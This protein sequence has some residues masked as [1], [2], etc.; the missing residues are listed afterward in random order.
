LQCL[1]LG[2]ITE[3]FY[4]KKLVEYR[5]EQTNIQIKQKQLQ[6]VDE[7]YY[8]TGFYLLKLA[9]KDPAIFKSS[10][11]EV[12]RQLINLVGQNPTINDETL[13]A[14]YRNPFSM[15]AKGASS[16][17]WLLLFSFEHFHQ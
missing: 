15:F 6:G 14:T 8:T 9:N 3:D 10:E 4:S 5:T 16:H 7:D 12:K 1:C 13:C 17:N 2:K 11:P